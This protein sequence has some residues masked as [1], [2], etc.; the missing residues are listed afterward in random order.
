[1]SG[2]P[3]NNLLQP[4]STSRIS[5]SVQNVWSSGP[6]SPDIAPSGINAGNQP[7]CSSRNAAICSTERVC[8]IQYHWKATGC[9]SYT[10]DCT[11]STNRDTWRQRSTRGINRNCIGRGAATDT[12][13]TFS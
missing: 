2:E 5:S 1:F 11:V 13:G 9:S 3:S 10:C 4:L 6:I 7:G 8:D 12:H